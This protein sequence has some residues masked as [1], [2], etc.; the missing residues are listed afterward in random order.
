MLEKIKSHFTYTRTFALIVLIIILFGAFLLCLPISSKEG[1]W[2]PFLDALFSSTSATCITGLTIFDTYS[3]LSLF[4]QIIILI[5]IQIGGIGFMTIVT[6]FFVILKKNIGLNERKFIMESTGNIKISGVIILVKRIAAGTLIFESCGAALLAVRFC[7][8]MGFAEGLYNAVF[9]SVSAFCNAGFD[10]MGKYGEFSSLTAYAGDTLVSVTIMLLIIIGGI[11]FLVWNDII[12][13]RFHIKQY[14]LHT[15]IVLVTSLALIFAGAILF[16]IFETNGLFGNLNTK[17]KILTAFFHS[18]TSRGAGFN[19]IETASMSESSKL[20]TQILMFIGGSPGSTAGGIKTTTFAVLLLGV[21]ASS[22]NNANITI[23]KRRLEDIA[24]RKATA[25]ATIYLLAILLSTLIICGIQDFDLADVSFEV[26]S[27][28]STTGLSTGI[29]PSL[30]PASRIIIILLMFS[31]RVGGLFLSL[32]F[33][34]KKNNAPINRPS[35]KI[36]I[37]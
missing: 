21:I 17:E 34:E 4:G 29:I 15:K 19:S 13:C 16:Y 12:K 11:G 36:L 2:T 33:A 25:I 10:I 7:P 3:H 35:E 23:F 1:E 8:Q 9:H 20:L 26:V 6:F 31:G 37:G 27:A 24:I 18:V 14:M 22:R 30:N 28:V 32:V 5:L